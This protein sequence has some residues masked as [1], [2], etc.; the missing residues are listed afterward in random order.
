MKI[1]HI[2]FVIDSNILAKFLHL[3]NPIFLQRYRISQDFANTYPFLCAIIIMLNFFSLSHT[4]TLS[5]VMDR[6]HFMLLPPPHTYK[7]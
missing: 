2:A 3:S 6:G 1:S 7:A 4:R 5:E